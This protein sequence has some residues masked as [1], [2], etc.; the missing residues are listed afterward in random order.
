MKVSYPVE[1][2]EYVEAVGIS[3]ELPFSWWTAHVLKGDRE[4]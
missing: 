2:A 4:S 1:G 3:D